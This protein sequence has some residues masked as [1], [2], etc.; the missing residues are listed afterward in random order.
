MGSRPHRVFTAILQFLRDYWSNDGY[1][2]VQTFPH[3]PEIAAPPK[4]F[5]IKAPKEP[6]IIMSFAHGLMSHR[7]M[8]LVL[9]PIFECL[10]RSLPISDN[11]STLPTEPSENGGSRIE[12]AESSME[13]VRR[14]SP[15]CSYAIQLCSRFDVKVEERRL[16]RLRL[17]EL[18]FEISVTDVGLR[19]CL[20]IKREVAFALSLTAAD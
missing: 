14:S 5:V 13:Q 3:R 9:L 16:Y 11:V 1:S 10:Q 7:S 15:P 20:P 12:P 2:G 19:Q 8:P 18:R 4:G 6:P 17:S